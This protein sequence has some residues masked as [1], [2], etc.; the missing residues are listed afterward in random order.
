MRWTEQANLLR[1]KATEDADA[2][3]AL[4]PNTSIADAIIGFHAQ[5]TVEKALKAVLAWRG[6]PYRR[7]HDLKE[8]YDLLVDHGVSVPSDV[9]DALFLSPFG[10]L[11]RYDDPPVGGWNRA[12]APRLVRAV[13]AWCDAEVPAPEQDNVPAP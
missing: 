4:V 13:L 3:D 9:G 12:D 7:V 5:Q 10:A 1:R 2:V 8:L 6:I 11:F